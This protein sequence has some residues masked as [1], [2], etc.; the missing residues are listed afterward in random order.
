MMFTQAKVTIMI[1][2]VV[3][4]VAV[5]PV[6]LHA[7]EP[8]ASDPRGP[9]VTLAEGDVQVKIYGFSSWKRA[10]EGLII[11]PGDTVRTGSGSRAEI[12]HYSGTIR[13]HENTVLTVPSIISRDGNRDLGEV[14]L[15]DGAGLFRLDS[16]QLKGGFKVRTRHVIAGVKGTTFA[17]RTDEKSTK[18]AVYD[19]TVQV[20]ET[21][22]SEGSGKV[23]NKGRSVQAVMGQGLGE[24]EKFNHRD[25]W[26][27]W[28]RGNA[29]SSKG[30]QEHGKKKDKLRFNDSGT[31]NNGRAIGKGSQENNTPGI[32]DN[33]TVVDQA[34]ATEK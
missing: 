3:A 5:L 34:P 16:E 24:A 20:R 7:D 11:G 31:Q 33:G 12:Q 9:V 30:K 4:M 19:G 18:V 32:A 15:E 22:N 26:K 28:Q 29:P 21:G 1:F 23:V 2:A 17:V 14:V 25:G 10:V 6:P 13:L 27:A 8:A